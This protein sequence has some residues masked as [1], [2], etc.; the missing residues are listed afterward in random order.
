MRP[1]EQGHQIEPDPVGLGGYEEA[2]GASEQRQ[3]LVGANQECGHFRLK[4]LQLGTAG[5]SGLEL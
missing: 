2:T 3:A 1:E 5:I 4:Y